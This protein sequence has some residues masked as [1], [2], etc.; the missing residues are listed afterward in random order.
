MI[1]IL[2]AAGGSRRMGFDKLSADLLGMPVVAR[3]LLAFERSACVER[4]LVVAKEE[5]LAEFEEMGRMHGVSKLER[6][7]AGG[8]ERR[9][10]V[11]NG[12]RAAQLSPGQYVAVHDAAR[13]LI[14]PRAIEGCLALAR[15]HGAAS[16]A[17]AVADTLKRADE[18]KCVTGSVE[19]ENLWA[20]QTP[21][22]FEASLLERAYRAV[23]EKGMLVTDDVSAVRAIGVPVQLVPV[24]APNFKITFPADLEL[25]RL[26]MQQR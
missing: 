4:I 17:A 14:T 3:S 21:Q 18:N 1:A 13:P 8:V 10:S 9:D 5:R 11:W 25:A 23:L 6:V 15:K 16:C 7:V 19:R 20:M 22:I 12:L 26:V 24:T 2:V